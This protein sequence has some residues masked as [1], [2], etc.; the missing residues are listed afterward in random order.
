LVQQLFAGL[1]PMVLRYS[2]LQTDHTLKG[3]GG[4]VQWAWG[5]VSHKLLHES[6]L[7]LTELQVPEKVSRDRTT[8][9]RLDFA[10]GGY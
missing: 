9:A 3:V 8:T 5:E 2:V 6:P 1:T 10:T 7:W 4:D